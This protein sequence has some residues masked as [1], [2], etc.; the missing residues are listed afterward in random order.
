MNSTRADSDT[1]RRRPI[2]M[3]RTGGAECD[4]PGEPGRRENT[5]IST[6]TPRL[7][8]GCCCP[9]SLTIGWPYL[10]VGA[11]GFASWEIAG[12]R[13]SDCALDTKTLSIANNRVSAGGR[14][15]ENDP[16]S[17]SSRRTLPLPD[18]L[19]SVLKAAKARQAC[20]RLSLGSA[21]GSA[22]MWCPTRSASPT[23]PRCCPATGV[24]R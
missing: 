24:T 1:R 8:C 3:L 15:V 18:R 2:L 13:W 19:V 20:E 16:K 12:L 6:P 21:Y 17:A 14:S 11:D 7:R 5:K 9:R 22:P 4:R 23:H 10:G